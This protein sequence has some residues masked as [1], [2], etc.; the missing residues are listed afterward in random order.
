L[1]EPKAAIEWLTNPNFVSETVSDFLTYFHILLNPQMNH[2]IKFF[3][4]RIKKL[5]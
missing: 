2:R 5:T 3:I 4:W 1:P